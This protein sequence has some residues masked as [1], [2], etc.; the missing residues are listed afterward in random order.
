MLVV[1]A[2]YPGFLRSPLIGA[3]A[4]GFKSGHCLAADPTV[5][6]SPGRRPEPTQS[7]ATEPTFKPIIGKRPL[8]RAS[9]M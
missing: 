6:F 5:E 4:I 8:R 2:L 9:K 7:A 3:E 1:I